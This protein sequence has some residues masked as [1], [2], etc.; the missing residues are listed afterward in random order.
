MNRKRNLKVLGLALIV[1]FGLSALAAGAAQANAPRWTVT[2]GGVAKTLGAAETREFTTKSTT[3]FTLGA[4]G[5]FGIT[6]PSCTMSGT[7]R[8]SGVGESGTNENVL[9]HC[10]EVQ[11]EGN[12]S[13]VVHSPGAPDGTIVS[14]KLSSKL[15]WLNATGDAEVGDTFSGIDFNI[16]ITK[17]VLEGEYTVHGNLIAKIEPVTEH[18]VEGQLTFPVVQIKKYWDNE[19]PTRKSTED[20]GLLIGVR[21]AIFTGW[22]ATTGVQETGI[23][24]MTLAENVEWGIEPG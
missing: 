10:I 4:A 6:S 1:V 8:G 2:V 23:M 13:C 5:L 24:D 18:K 14:N 17:C 16:E 20:T 11:V 22:N 9:L 7:I 19:T 15:V 3:G 21:P 12:K